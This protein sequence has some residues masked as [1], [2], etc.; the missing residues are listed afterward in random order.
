[1]VRLWDDMFALCERTG[2]RILLTPMDTF[3]QWINWKRHPFNRKNGGPCAAR[4]RLMVD[5]ETRAAIK[6]RI[7][8]VTRRWGGIGRAVRVGHLERDAPRAG[9]Q[10][11][12]L[13]RLYW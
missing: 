8:F 4:S 9:G 2:M 7:A 13:R 10:P 5:P 1:M 6:N 12:T 3:F 11:G